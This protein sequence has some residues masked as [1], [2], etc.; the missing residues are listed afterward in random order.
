MTFIF[1]PFIAII[2]GALQ[3]DR[4]KVIESG[5]DGHIAKLVMQE[6]LHA[7]LVKWGFT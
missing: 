7:E 4:S 1:C 6:E 5:M 2:A 3:T